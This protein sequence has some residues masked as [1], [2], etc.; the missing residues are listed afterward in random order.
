MV[1]D[2]EIYDLVLKKFAD[3]GTHICNE[4]ETR[5]LGRTVIDP[6]TGC[7]QPKAVGQKAAD[8]ARTA[9]LASG[10]I[11]AIALPEL[12]TSLFLPDLFCSRCGPSPC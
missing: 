7:M 3:L 8:I 10:S 9:G 5:Q 6:K 11:P 2:D 4:K 12:C 1:I